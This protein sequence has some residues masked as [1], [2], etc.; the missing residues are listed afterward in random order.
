MEN[1]FFFSTKINPLKV[2]KGFFLVL[3]ASLNLGKFPI[4][5]KAQENKMNNC[6]PTAN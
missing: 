6:E 4:A 5:M 1:L 3:E 2:T